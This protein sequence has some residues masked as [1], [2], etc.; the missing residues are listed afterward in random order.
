MMIKGKII[1][2]R[3]RLASLLIIF[4]WLTLP[5]CQYLSNVIR[6]LNIRKPVVRV[7]NARVAGIGFD[8][9]TLNFAVGVENP[10]TIGLT[11]DGFDYELMINGES[12]L[13][14]KREEI[15]QLKAGE[16]SQ[17][18]FPL[19]LKFAEIVKTFN[20]LTSGDSSRYEIYLGLLFDIPVLGKTRIPVNH[21]GYFPLVKFPRVSV[22]GL[23]LEKLSITGAFMVLQVK[24]ENPNDFQLSFENL[25]YRLRVNGNEWVSGSAANTMSVDGKGNNILNIPVNLDFLS[26]GSQIYSLIRSGDRLNYEFSG[27]SNIKGTGPL[28]DNET[29]PFNLSGTINLSR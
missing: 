23:K 5:S 29:V 16:N 12:F 10:N 28:S 20:T 22:S 15:I 3:K 17:F 9:I 13:Q 21:S 8:Q 19:T 1:A 4:L 24:V 26:L 25:D 7:T 27:A 18:D 14:G 11:L 2:S 6:Q